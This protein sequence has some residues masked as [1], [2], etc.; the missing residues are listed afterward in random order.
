MSKESRVLFLHQHQPSGRRSDAKSILGPDPFD[1]SRLQHGPQSIAEAAI[2]MPAVVGD[3][4]T[5]DGVVS[6]G[7]FGKVLARSPVD[8][9]TPDG[10][11]D[12]LHCFLG[13]SRHADSFQLPRSGAFDDSQFEVISKEGE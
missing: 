11:R 4:T 1:E 10:L 8:S 13:G 5:D 6:S 9:P 7:Q 3:P 2:P 12:G